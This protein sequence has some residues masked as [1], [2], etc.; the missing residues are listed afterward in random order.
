MTPKER[1]ELFNELQQAGQLEAWQ[2]EQNRV[3]IRP[4]GVEIQRAEEA[5]SWIPK[6]IGHDRENAMIVGGWATRTYE[7]DAEIP[8]P[9]R[10]G[11]REIARGLRR[12][13][14]PVRGLSIHAQMGRWRWPV[15]S[16]RD[17]PNPVA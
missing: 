4:T 6:Y 16:G 11:L 10:P 5:L 8:G 7:L 15:G 13:R 9:V 2:R 12:D 14:V 1:V 17:T 3:R